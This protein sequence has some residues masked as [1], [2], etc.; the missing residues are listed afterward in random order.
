MPR[1]FLLQAGLN[2]EGF[3]PRRLQRRARFDDRS[4]GIGQ[5]SRR[6]QHLGVGEVRRR[7]KVDTSQVRV[8]L[9]TPPYYDLLVG[10]CGHA[11]RHAR[12][13]AAALLSLKCDDPVGKEILDLGVQRF[14]EQ[15]RQLQGHRSRGEGAELL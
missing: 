2:P 8:V 1:S 6:A 9:T 12:K 13:L 15:G 4:R 10:A 7:E 5:C 14:I 11:G 3:P